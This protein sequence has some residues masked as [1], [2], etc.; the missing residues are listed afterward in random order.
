MEKSPAESRWWDW[1]AIALLFVLLQTVAARLVTTSWTPFLYL[2]QTCT[3]IG[4]IVG[5]A[6]GYSQFHRRTVRW[7]T[8]FYLVMMLPL[9]W[10]LVIDQE[11]SL[12]EQLGSVAGRLFF[13]VSDFLARRPVEDPFFFVAIMTILFWILSAS[14]GFQLTRRQ[15]YL[16]A[17]LPSAI[18]LLIIQSYDNS[19]QGRIWILAFFAFIALLLLGRMNFLD[20][21]ESWRERRVFLSPD[22]RIDLTTTMAIAAG[23]I[24]LVS[25][26]VPPTL[27]N[28]DSVVKTWNRITRPW[29]DFTHN[30]ENA[31]EA[32][33][34]PS[35]GRRG[36]FFGSELALGLGFP[37]SD[38]VIFTVTA[39]DLPAAERPPR[40]YWRGRTYDYFAKEQWYTTGTTREDYSPASDISTLINIELRK[41]AR[42][43]FN[44]GDTSSLLYAPAQPIWVSRPGVTRTIPAEAGK[45]IISWSAVPSLLAGETYQVDAVLNNP[46]ITQLRAAGQEYPQWVTDK[47]LQLP[48]DF[49]PRIRQLAAD[50]VVQ[51]ETPYDAAMAITRYLRENIEYKPTIEKTPRNKDT[52]EWILFEYKQGY[53]VYYASSEILMLRSLGIPARMAVGFAQGEHSTENNIFTV[54]RFHSHAWPEVYFPGVGW[55]E[56]EPTANQTALNRP[57]ESQNPSDENNFF[58][59][60]PERIEDSQIVGGREPLEDQLVQNNLPSRVVGSLLLIPLL[61]VLAG[62]TIFLNRRYMLHER[63]PSLIRGTMERTGIEAPVWIIRWERWVG[64][65]PIERAFESINFGLRLLDESPPIHATPGERADKLSHILTPMA[66]QIKVLLEEHQTSLYTS[67]TADI[68]QARRAAFNIRVQTI[69]ARVRHLFTG[70][71]VTNS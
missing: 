11:V 64:L 29:R 57:V 52:L 62:L 35:G 4:Y 67:R 23:L 25:W 24:I 59:Q 32:L 38:S 45:D 56:F 3:Y 15:N 66:D 58:P 1:A 42:F 14:A 49:S 10:T 28:L 12:E 27:S 55:V 22:N 46:N 2:A 36:E 19:V 61:I 21:Q 39:P 63:L 34:S 69:R 18:G 41:P 47:Y 37:L 53:C 68:N 71:Y 13:S 17:V 8:F 60:G 44:T 48:E 31:V 33:E 54:R 30:M 9:Q 16:A 26:T 51:A 7:L 43:I 50:I 70:S 6:L 40:Y 20:N 5:T 65:S